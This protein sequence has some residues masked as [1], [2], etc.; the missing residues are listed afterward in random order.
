MSRCRQ[1]LKIAAYFSTVAH[2]LARIAAF[3]AAIADNFV[4][5]ASNFL[6][7]TILFLKIAFCFI[8][9]SGNISNIA[10]IS[11]AFGNFNYKR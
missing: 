1:V 6:K 4:K 2:N 8:I 11:S 3:F 10:T 5:I 7:I 9:F